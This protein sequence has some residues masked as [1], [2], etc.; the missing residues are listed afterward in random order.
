MSETL[1]YLFRMCSEFGKPLNISQRKN[2]GQ[3]YGDVTS[4]K[5]PENKGLKYHKVYCCRHQ[6]SVSRKILQQTEYQ[7]LVAHISNHSKIFPDA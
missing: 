5:A 3:D 7:P 2:R 6:S 1:Y 4:P